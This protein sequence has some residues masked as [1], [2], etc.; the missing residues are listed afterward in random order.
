MSIPKCKPSFKQYPINESRKDSSQSIHHKVYRVKHAGQRVNPKV[1]Q[2]LGKGTKSKYSTCFYV[3]LFQGRIFVFKENKEKI[4][5]KRNCNIGKVAMEISMY[6][7]TGPV[8]T[9]HKDRCYDKQYDND[10]YFF[11]VHI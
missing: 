11:I 2:C 4:I 8:S 7:F 10:G 9:H 6:S 3:P 1:L 5:S